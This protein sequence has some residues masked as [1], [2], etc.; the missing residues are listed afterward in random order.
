M[1]LQVAVLIAV[2]IVLLSI[3]SIL[4]RKPQPVVSHESTI[5]KDVLETLID[6]GFTKGDAMKRV[7]IACRQCGIADFNKL[8]N[9]ALNANESYD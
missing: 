8:L 5:Q 6:L 7:G 9:A 4:D 1:S 2:P 3:I